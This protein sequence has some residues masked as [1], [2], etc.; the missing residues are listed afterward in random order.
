M[1][2][3]TTPQEGDLPDPANLAFMI[4]Q[5][6]HS[7]VVSGFTF[8]ADFATPAVD[9]GPGK[10]VVIR[11]DI[12][13]VDPRID[14]PETRRDAVALVET[15]TQTVNLTDGTTNH[16]FLD[17]N[18]DGADDTPIVTA[19]TTAAKPTTA[20]LKLGEV[21]T[22]ADTVSEGWYRIA[23]D[24]TLTFPDESAADAASSELR[25]G[26]IVYERSTDTHFFSN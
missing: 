15:D 5:V 20:S 7:L 17:A 24:G 12:S 16:V 13:T 1:V 11:G 23:G 19:N 22:S 8:T 14:P 25:E 26:T 9:I 18:V 10:A 6:S 21:D 3:F 4:G 2:E